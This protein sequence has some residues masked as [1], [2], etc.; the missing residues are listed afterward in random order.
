[1]KRTRLHIV[2]LVLTVAGLLSCSTPPPKTPLN[3]PKVP[4][5]SAEQEFAVST[6]CYYLALR[7]Q[8]ALLIHQGYRD[9]GK[10][11][12]MARANVK[13]YRDAIRETFKESKIANLEDLLSDKTGD[14]MINDYINKDLQ[15]VQPTK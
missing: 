13:E 8:V 6:A 10:I 1:M 9:A 14:T 11:R 7:Q 12:A 3:N 4:I 2:L 5:T 15:E